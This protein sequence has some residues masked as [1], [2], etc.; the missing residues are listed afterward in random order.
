MEIGGIEMDIYNEDIYRVR[1]WNPNDG[2]DMEEAQKEVFAIINKY[3]IPITKV[4][5]LF[6]STLRDIEDKNIVNL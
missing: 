4:R 2:E 6:L 1:E 3:Q 5:C